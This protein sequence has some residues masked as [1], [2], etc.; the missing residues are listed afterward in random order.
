MP[1]KRFYLNVPFKDKEEA[2]ALGAIWDKNAKKY[3][4]PYYLDL[5]LFSKWSED[6]LSLKTINK[7]EAL[8]Q[9]KLA[10]EHFGLIIDDY[11]IMNGKIQ[12]CQVYGDKGSEKSGAY[13]GYLDEYPAGFMQNFKTGIKEKW[14]FKL[15]N[16]SQNT[17][18]SFSNPIL[19]N[20]QKQKQ[21]DLELLAL[22]E[23]TALRLEKEWNMA[24]K[25]SNSHLYLKTKGL[26][27][28]Y[29][30]KVDN[31]NNLLIPLKDIKGKFWSLQRIA[32]NGKKII[33]VIKTKE[34][35]EQNIEYSARKKACFYTQTPLE[36]QEEFLICEGFATAMSLQKI[37]H[38]PIIMAIDSGNLI[39]VVETLNQNYPFNPIT[40]Y[41]DNDLKNS[42]N[43]GLNSAKAIKEK[44]KDIKVF[45]PKINEIEAQQGLSDF[46]DIFKIYGLEKIKEKIIELL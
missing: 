34:E 19:K 27:S 25:A 38:K 13:C 6:N 28:A 21:K 2:K 39:S 42:N 14:K 8:L 20:S 1:R 3:F 46:N 15:H 30:L 24:K 16:Q 40:I 37:L 44:Y 17:K 22:Q 12:R 45:Y 11:P 23:K 4:V 35:K 36:Q 41:A 9:F 7:D 33:G 43:T 5:S 32:E 18:Q 26:D 31:F 10:L 29:D